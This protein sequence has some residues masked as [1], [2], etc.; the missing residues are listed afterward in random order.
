MHYAVAYKNY[1]VVDFLT[2]HG[3][4]EDILNND[5]MTP[6]EC[7]NKNLENSD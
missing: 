7:A 2:Q 4:R 1:G 6:W 5:K 3:G